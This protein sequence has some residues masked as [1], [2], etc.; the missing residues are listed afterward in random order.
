MAA[1]CSST[2]PGWWPR[3]RSG[4]VW[5]VNA[6]APRIAVEAAAEAGVRRVIVTSS[7]A[8]I[9]PAPAD[10]PADERRPYP[11]G[12]HGPAL[13]GLQARGR[14][15]RAGGRAA[16]PGSRSWPSAPPTCSGPAFNRSLPGETS[17]RI[18]ANY[19]RGRLPAIVDSY[20][21]IVDVEDVARGPPAGRRA[22]G[23]P[24]E[25]YILGGENLRWSEVIERDR[26][27][28]GRPP[29]ADRAAARDGRQR[30]RAASAPVPL[31]IARGHPP[32][33]AGLALLV[34]EARRELG[35]QPARRERDAQAHGRL[36]PGA[37][38][39]RP[40]A[41]GAQQQSFDLMT[42]GVRH[43]RPARAAAARCKAAGQLA[44]RRTVL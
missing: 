18:V 34:G 21:N 30:R 23:V 37:D 36:V 24:G 19:L 16:R 44:G 5:R 25:R 7:V 15:G 22:R 38:R 17:T 35:Y 4:E 31:G 14:A 10:A 29:P 40:P 11:A 33:G 27:A 41:R 42:A 6:V 9:G 3:A 13:H 1:T 20:T 26:A 32:D 43:R 28:L 8:A 39:G 12:R 2:R